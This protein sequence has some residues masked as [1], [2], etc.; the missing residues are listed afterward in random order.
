MIVQFGLLIFYYDIDF[1]FFLAV[2]FKKEEKKK[3][4]FLWDNYV[5]LLMCIDM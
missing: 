2:E 1:M 3:S 4:L 5:D